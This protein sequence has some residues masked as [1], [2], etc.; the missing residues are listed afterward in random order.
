MLYQI[1][2]Y[3]KKF[4]SILLY[5]EVTENKYF[6]PYTFSINENEIKRHYNLPIVVYI[7]TITTP[8]KR[9]TPMAIN[10]ILSIFFSIGLV[11]CL[12]A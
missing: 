4:F 3:L 7:I 10:I 8:S 12:L 11:L 5:A 9:M 1:F 6:I 2:D